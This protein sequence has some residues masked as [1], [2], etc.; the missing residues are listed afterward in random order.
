MMQSLSPKTP[1]EWQ[2]AV[3][4]ADVLLRLDNAR[5]YGLVTGGPEIDADRCLELLELGR[6]RGFEPNP[7]RKRGAA[8]RGDGSPGMS[9]QDSK[10]AIIPYP[11]HNDLSQFHSPALVPQLIADQGQEAGWK[12]LEFFTAGIHN[13]NTRKAYYRAVLNFCNWAQSY[14]LTLLSLRPLHTATWVKQ[15]GSKLSAPSV[16][17]HLAAVRMLFDFLV[18]NQVVPVNPAASVKGPSYSVKCGKTPVLT[19]DEAKHLLASI[20]L[21]CE[22]DGQP[23]PHLVGL[24]DRALISVLVYTFARVGAAV[25][26]NVEDYFPQG[27]RWWCCLHEKGGKLHKMPAH[28]R[29]EE[30]LDAYLD[31]AGLWEKKK[32]PLFRTAVGKTKKITG[33]RM[34]TNDVWAMVQRRA[35]DAKIETKIGCHTFRATGI[36]NYLE[37]GGTLEKAQAMANHESP[38]T[39][40]L[41]DRTSDQLSLDEVERI[42]I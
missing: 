13:N 14:G 26:M 1:S 23:V 30:Y 9:E 4:A 33:R 12:F 2:A 11:G 39:T 21:T 37:N 41:Y 31:A 8:R 24:R 35:R 16:K 18:I 10:A 29:A 25:A 3:D 32:E 7:R 38:R 17:Q 40:K 6:N 15:L 42:S 28:H 20:K 19:E 22:L 34:T 27:K 36:T 5:A